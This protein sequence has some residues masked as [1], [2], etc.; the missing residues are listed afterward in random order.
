MEG[1]VPSSVHS[2]A[3]GSS[4]VGLAVLLLR[5]AW[6]GQR[7]R[8]WGRTCK[9]GPSLSPCPGPLLPG[10]RGCVRAEMDVL[11]VASRLV[12]GRSGLPLLVHSRLPLPTPKPRVALGHECSCKGPSPPLLKPPHLSLSF[13]LFLFSSFCSSDK[14]TGPQLGHGLLGPGVLELVL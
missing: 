9:P 4:A 10:S 11:V 12:V 6:K 14:P 5:M 2:R 7:T 3:A 8:T 13:S 1:F